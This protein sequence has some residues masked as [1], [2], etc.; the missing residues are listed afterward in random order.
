MRIDFSRGHFSKL[1]VRAELE[2]K[3]QLKQKQQR[4][5]HKNN[6]K[7]NEVVMQA[8]LEY[9]KHMINEVHYKQIKERSLSL[10]NR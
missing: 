9:K 6:T 4:Y 5:L 1:H 3:T 7:T 2:H 10:V 8:L